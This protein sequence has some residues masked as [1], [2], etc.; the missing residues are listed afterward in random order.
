MYETNLQNLCQSTLRNIST[1]H[2][3]YTCFTQTRVMMFHAHFFNSFNH[4]SKQLYGKSK[5]FMYGK[6]KKREGKV[7]LLRSVKLWYIL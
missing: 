3:K 6:E 1:G 5:I 7:E 2:E 4:D